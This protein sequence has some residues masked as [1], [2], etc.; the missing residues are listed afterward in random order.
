MARIPLFPVPIGLA[1][2]GALYFIFW[3]TPDESQMGPVYKIFYFHVSSAIA[4]LILIFSCSLLSVVYLLMRR[5]KGME[6]T[7]AR[8]DW[9]A[10]S[11]A[12]IGLLFGIIVLLTGPIWA[13]PAWGT[14]WT[15]EPRLT[16]MLL[17]AFLLVGY[18]VLRRYGHGD[19][20]SRQL[21]A[22]IAVVGGPAC[23]FIHYAVKLWGGNHPVV[24]TEGGG[25]LQDPAMQIAFAWTASAVGSLALYLVVR[26]FKTHR[27][28][29]EI[30]ALYAE[31]SDCEARA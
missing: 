19:S 3:E 27:M 2:L 14:Y 13:K 28:Q 30:D 22:G 6:R 31:V 5:L 10:V 23:W 24:I 17:L 18:L 25:G 21:S 7:A 12:E 9:V 4:S 1:L 26:R 15:W 11:T 20:T 29:D 8:V 16:L